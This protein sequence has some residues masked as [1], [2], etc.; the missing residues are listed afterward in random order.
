MGEMVH[1]QEDLKR[2]GLHTMAAIIDQEV[3]KAIKSQASYTAFLQRLVEEELVAKTDRSVNA[4]IAKARFPAIRT[5]EAF[6]FG[7]QPQLAVAQVKELAGLDFLDRAENLCAVGPPGTGKTH[8][9]I[10]LAMKACQARKRVLFT[11][12][13]ALLDTLV[14]CTVDGSLGRRL[15]VDSQGK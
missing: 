4:R 1:L 8:L 6:D 14:A 11:H 7:F 9:L 13:P 10:G 3:G 2:L 5:L 15:G 12:A